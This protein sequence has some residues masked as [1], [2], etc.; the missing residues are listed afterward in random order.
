VSV[1]EAPPAPVQVDSPA[2]ATVGR[3]RVFG[4]ALAVLLAMLVVRNLALFSV[5]VNEEGDSAANSIITYQAKHFRLLVGNYSRLGFSHPGPAFFYVRAFGEWFFHDV[6]GLV[7][8]PWNGQALAVLVLNAAL[9]AAGLSV[10]A[11]W[12]RTWLGVALPAAALLGYLAFHGEIAS[13]TWMP[14]EYVAPFLLLL[15]AAASVATGRGRDLWALALA[16][17]L[18]I[19]GHAE[20]LLFV[21]VIAGAAL[22]AFRYRP[23]RV[24]ARDWLLAAGIVAL[25]AAPI[26]VNVV[27]HWPGDFGRYFGYGGTQGS[28]GHPV[29]G[30]AAYTMRFWPGR[31]LAGLAVAIGLFAAVLALGWRQRHPLLRAGAAA[32]GLALLLFA[33]YAAV[34]I[35]DLSQDYVGLFMLAVPVFLIA[36][37]GLAVGD[38]IPDRGFSRA[39]GATVVVAGLAV[40]LQAPDL[41]TRREQLDNV[42]AVID[43]MAARAGHRPV[44]LRTDH[45][46]W[47]ELDALIV[48]G[49]RRGVRVCADD[50]SWRF[51]VTAEFVCTADER[52]TGQ[53]FL[54]STTVPAGGNVLANVGRAVVS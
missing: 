2:P 12:A 24:R 48:G 50:P 39:V 13:S 16:G 21:P 43:A 6:L 28:H 44:V 47:P 1:S 27:L 30:A 14:F 33:G 10:L 19:H 17:G 29:A 53:S 31:G 22:V 32:G 23:H 15:V 3:W 11:G 38:L 4:I 35:D 5:V 41:T 9:L 20:F 8:S 7:A 51:M 34:G 46:A 26:V 36:L 40:A 45:D 25:F 18:L 49:L 37:I 54:L 52:A 42:P